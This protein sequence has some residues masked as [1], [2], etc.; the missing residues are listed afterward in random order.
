MLVQEIMQHEVIS[1]PPDFSLA[2][3]LDLMQEHRIRHVPVVSGHQIIGLLTDRDCRQAMPSSAANLSLEAIIAE[4]ETL[5]IA[6]CMTAPVVTVPT[7]VDSAE[8]ARKLLD[9]KFDCLPVVEQGQLVGIVTAT[10]FLRGF[11]ETANSSGDDRRVCEYMQMPPLTVAPTDI[12]RTAYHRMRC[13]NIRHLPVVAV[14]CQLVGLLTDRDIRHQQASAI[15][16]LSAYEWWEPTYTLTVQEVM[17]L[18]VAT[19]GI[20]TP[21]VD[22]AERLLSH[23]FG[24]LPVVSSHNTLEGILTVRDLVR[25][26]VQQRESGA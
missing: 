3:A 7:V 6:T 26:Y 12:V 14:G 18:H 2:D 24:C 13:A 4:L 22:A 20:D 17:T 8:A 16:P 1:A 21:V 9:G 19:V 11:L 15:P 5:M 10:D 23:R 25:G